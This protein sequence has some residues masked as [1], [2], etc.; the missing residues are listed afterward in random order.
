MQD[1]EVFG[2]FLHECE[3]QID[4]VDSLLLSAESGGRFSEDTIDRL[5]RLV[6]TLKGTAAMMGY[7]ALAQVTHQGE[8]VLQEVR[9][10]ELAAQNTSAALW[11]E[12]IGRGFDFTA[13][14][15]ET[16]DQLKRGEEAKDSP[17]LRE[18]LSALLAALYGEAPG[19][20]WRRRAW[21][22]SPP[23]PRSA[24]RILR[25]LH[26]AACTCSRVQ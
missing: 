7:T 11:K 2:L 21:R 8:N 20:A 14:Y 10:R 26:A 24:R 18:K 16:F 5:F 22:R 19:P 23:C 9:R 13:Y 15:R 25:A 4:E 3:Q 17:A 1:S 12:I 6:H